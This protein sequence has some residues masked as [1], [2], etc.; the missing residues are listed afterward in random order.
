MDKGQTTAD[1]NSTI[2]QKRGQ[3]APLRGR[4][5]TA[6][7]VTS[8]TCKGEYA[9]AVQSNPHVSRIPGDTSKRRFEV[10]IDLFSLYDLV[11]GPNRVRGAGP[12]RVHS[13]NN[14]PSQ[15]R[16]LAV[17]DV[18]GFERGDFRRFWAVLFD[19]GR[20]QQR[21]APKTHLVSRFLCWYGTN[22]VK[23][24]LVSRQVFSISR[25]TYPKAV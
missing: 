20:F 16:T 25:T 13:L 1:L 9:K 23:S 17:P 15:V 5:L 12:V 14:V 7:M 10:T 3:V 8:W 2:P 19:F 11:I 18:P 24:A 22:Y 4:S 6:L 21:Y